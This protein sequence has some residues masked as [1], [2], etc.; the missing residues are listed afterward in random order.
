MEEKMS[1]NTHD[2]Q[3]LKRLA[4]AMAANPRATTQELATAAGISRATF[5]RFCG[6]RENLVEMIAE[7][8]QN[9]LQEIVT[10]EKKEVSDYP[11]SIL[12]LIKAHLDNEEYLSF[13][14]EAQNNLGNTYWNEYLGALDHFFL[15]GQKAGVFQLD[16][17]NQ[18]MSE[19]FVSMIC[20]MMDAKS[21]GRMAASGMEHKMLAF[22]L[23]GSAQTQP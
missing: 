17:P 20:G 19:L 14:C 12:E 21:R 13:A 4:A 9:V 18:M 5:N 8:A 16:F 6:T 2:E 7:Q 3:L 11:T 22:F 10:I 1:N 23:N 15:N